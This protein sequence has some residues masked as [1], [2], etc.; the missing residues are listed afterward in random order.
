[1]KAYQYFI[2]I[3]DEND[4]Y[5][6]LISRRNDS[7]SKDNSKIINPKG[8]KIRFV[9]DRYIYKPALV[10]QFIFITE[11]WADCLSLEE[12]GFNAI[13]LNSTSNVTKFLELLTQ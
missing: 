6:Y 11:G 3:L 9:N 5:S 8:L 7:I 13:S 2:P 10:E 1:M 4:K 12:L